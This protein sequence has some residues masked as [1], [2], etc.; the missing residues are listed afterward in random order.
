MNKTTPYYALNRETGHVV[1]YRLDGVTAEAML[2][3]GVPLRRG[4]FDHSLHHVDENGK[5]IPRPEMKVQ[6][7]G[8]KLTGLPKPC[9]VWIDDEM[10]E[11]DDGEAEIEFPR[12]GRFEVVVLAHPYKET[13]L[14]IE[15]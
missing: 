11:C 7:D 5:R 12:A 10:Y 3:S 1:A 8:K 14:T 4:H 15:N 2:A 13:R 6:W 9:T